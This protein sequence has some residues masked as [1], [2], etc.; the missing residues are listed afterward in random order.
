MSENKVLR[1]FGLKKVEVKEEREIILGASQ[2][3]LLS[4]Y[5][6]GDKTKEDKMGARH[7]R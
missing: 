3:V 7:K 6:L 1:I 5:C 4:K 2:F